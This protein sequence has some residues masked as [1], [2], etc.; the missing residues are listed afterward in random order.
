MKTSVFIIFL[1]NVLV[2]ILGQVP[3]VV[4][5]VVGIG[6]T[7]GIISNWDSVQDI[8]INPLLT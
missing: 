3:S 4:V 2:L 7:P 8:D 6:H 1:T 5:G